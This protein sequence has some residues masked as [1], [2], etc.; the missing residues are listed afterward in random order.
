LLKTG[1]YTP[2]ISDVVLIEIGRCAAELRNRL[3][4]RLEEIS[5]EN[6]PVTE[7]IDDLAGKYC[8]EGIIPKKY[9]D[10]ALHI[11]AAT[12]SA[13]DVIVSWNFS[14]IVKL[15]TVRGVKGINLLLGYR[16]LEILTP[17]S[18]IE[19]GDGT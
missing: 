9:L 4:S 19:G 3:L 11:A 6:A 18:F 14:H 16:E 17:D 12:V 7:E 1:I 2:V 13:C 15:A 10:D 8:S 5:Y